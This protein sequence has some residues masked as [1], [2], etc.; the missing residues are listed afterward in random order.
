M[1]IGRQIGSPAMERV[2]MPWP[3][4]IWS[5]CSQH[6]MHASEHN[7]GW[8]PPCCNLRNKALGP[9]RVGSAGSGARGDAGDF[10]KDHQEIMQQSVR[11]QMP[12][13]VTTVGAA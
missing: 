5:V 3:R 9:C 11:M 13:F 1:A 6:G 7:P 8:Q 2:H 12:G 4:Q 10:S